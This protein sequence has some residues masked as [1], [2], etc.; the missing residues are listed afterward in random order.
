MASGTSI[1][2][3]MG[4]GF[5]LTSMVMMVLKVVGLGFRV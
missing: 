2:T 4:P 3:A 1:L 5:P